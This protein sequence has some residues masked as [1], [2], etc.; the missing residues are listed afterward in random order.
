MAKLK[1][2]EAELYAKIRAAS[3]RGDDLPIKWLKAVKD[4]AAD[5]DTLRSNPIAYPWPLLHNFLADALVR[6]VGTQGVPF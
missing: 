5:L 4:P 1:Q 2:W 3:Y 6:M